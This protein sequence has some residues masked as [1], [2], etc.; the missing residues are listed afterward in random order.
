[1][2]DCDGEYMKCLCHLPTQDRPYWVTHTSTQSLLI[3]KVTGMMLFHSDKIWTYFTEKC[4][5]DCFF[6]LYPSEKLLHSMR[7]D[8]NEHQLKLAFIRTS[9]RGVGLTLS[10][11]PGSLAFSLLPEFIEIWLPAVLCIC[12]TESLLLPSFAGIPLWC[13]FLSD[14]KM[15]CHDLLTIQ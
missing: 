3:K 14:E 10:P 5:L 1:M 8:L 12:P 13:G 9:V 4:W 11:P 7:S 15:H 2:S 6:I